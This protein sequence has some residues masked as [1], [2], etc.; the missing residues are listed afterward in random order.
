MLGFKLNLAIYKYRGDRKQ[1]LK[2]IWASLNVTPSQYFIDF[3]ENYCGP[4]SSNDNG[5][6]LA[7]IVE[8]ESIVTLTEQSRIHHLFPEIF[9]TLSPLLGG[10]VLV[11]NSVTDEVFNVDFEGGDQ[12]LLNSSLKPTWASFEAFIRSYF[13]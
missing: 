9:L 7:D 8:D 6:E 4:F 3:Y 2:E 1:R 5:F 10:S 11:Y 12:E 13:S